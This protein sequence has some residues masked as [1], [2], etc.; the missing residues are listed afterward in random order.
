MYKYCKAVAIS[1]LQGLPVLCGAWSPLR[2]RSPWSRRGW[3]W[4]WGDMEEGSSSLDVL[5]LSAG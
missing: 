2:S 5:V 4:H 3:L 1:I